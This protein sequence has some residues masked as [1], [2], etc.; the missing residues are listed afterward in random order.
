MN[1]PEHDDE[2][3]LRVRNRLQVLEGEADRA[4]DLFA[5]ILNAVRKTTA[6]LEQ[7]RNERG[8]SDATKP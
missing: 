1:R 7:E 8:E 6:R 4:A 3:E 5:R 2:R